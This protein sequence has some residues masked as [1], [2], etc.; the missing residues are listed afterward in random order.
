[1]IFQKDVSVRLN[2]ANFD[3][4]TKIKSECLLKTTS[5]N[6]NRAEATRK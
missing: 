4:H 3:I 1:M 5:S 6:Y 2:F